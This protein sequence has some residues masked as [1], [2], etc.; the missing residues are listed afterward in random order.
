MTL[1]DCTIVVIQGDSPFAR[2]LRDAGANVV[3][4]PPLAICAPDNYE[5]FDQ[6]LDNLFGYDWLIL[7][8]LHSAEAFLSRWE[9]LGHANYELDD[10]RVCALDHE[11]A[12]RLADA[13]IHVDLVPDN[14]LPSSVLQALADYLD[15]TEHLALRNFLLPCA[16]ATRDTLPRLLE[17][18]EARADAVP[19]YRTTAPHTT[20]RARLDA[21][22]AAGSLDGII[23]TAPN[24]VMQLAQVL[25]THDLGATLRGLTIICADEATARQAAFYALNDYVLAE[26]PSALR[27]ALTNVAPP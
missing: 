14:P 13:H 24:E 21:L 15:G 23:F 10:V 6:A 11:T 4:C 7:S 5:L 25:D 27:Q 2:Q 8:N 16:V 19:A 26:T 18:T 3:V 20:E 12:T 9:E 22:L 17:E 1:Q